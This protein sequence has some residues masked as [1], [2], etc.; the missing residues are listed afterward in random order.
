MSRPVSGSAPKLGIAG[1]ITKATIRSPLTLLFLLAAFAVGLMA[2]AAIPRE[3]E[4][5]ISVPMVDVRL[6]APGLSADRSRLRSKAST[7][8]NMSIPDPRTMARW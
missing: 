6:M 8:S 2:L 3:E 5:Q 1:A 7:G 4:P